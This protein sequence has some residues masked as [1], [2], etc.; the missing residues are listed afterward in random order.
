MSINLN[1]IIVTPSID[2]VKLVSKQK[3]PEDGISKNII[4]FEREED[5][6][7]MCLRG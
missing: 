1:T 7:V 4:R 2:A 6:I 5:M 3:F